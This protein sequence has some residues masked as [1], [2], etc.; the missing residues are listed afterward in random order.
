MQEIKNFDYKILS[1]KKIRICLCRGTDISGKFPGWNI[2]TLDDKTLDERERGENAVKNRP[3]KQFSVL[4]RTLEKSSIVTDLQKIVEIFYIKL[5]EQDGNINAPKAINVLET[6]KDK[7]FDVVHMLTMFNK[8]EEQV[9][10]ATKPLQRDCILLSPCVSR[11]HPPAPVDFPCQIAIAV[12]IKLPKEEN[13]QSCGSA[14]DFVCPRQSNEIEID[15]PW[16]ASYH[17]AAVVILIL[18]KAYALG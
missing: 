11:I 7:R 16:A 9:V 4:V 10:D 12:G 13:Y 17:A 3:S 8:T 15:N 18:I 2:K 5:D 6:I 1:E 14:L